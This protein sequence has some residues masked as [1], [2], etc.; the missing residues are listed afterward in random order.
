[1]NT[2]NECRLLVDLGP[3]RIEKRFEK[4]NAIN[5]YRSA[6][7]RSSWAKEIAIMH[8]CTHTGPP[9]EIL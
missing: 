4:T 2:L 6:A 8:N 5:Y 7:K 3:I 9:I 1:M